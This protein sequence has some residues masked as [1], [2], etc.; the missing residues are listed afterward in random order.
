MD[1]ADRFPFSRPSRR[2]VLGALGAAA[3]AP[4]LA[5]A[6]ALAQPAGSAALAF[7]T[8]P[9]SGERLPAVGM[10]TYL[11]FDVLPG[12]PRDHLREVLR[13]FY[14]GGGRVVDTSPLYGM[15]E[16]S[17][18][19]FATALGITDDLF[20]TNKVWSTGEYLGDDSH[21]RRSLEQSRQRL[22]RERIDVMQ[23]HSLVNV[24]IM[25]PLLNAWKQE[26]RIRFV[27]VTHHEL[28]YFPA[29]AQWVERGEIDTVQVHYSIH[30]RQAEDRILKAA[31]DRGIAVLV[32]MPFEKARLFRI[33]EGRPLPDFAREIG[34]ETWAQFFL[35]WVISHPAVTC[36]LPATT[37]P[38]HASDNIAALRGPL[39]DAE[40]R[41]RMVRHME[42]IPG[43][44]DLAQ[45]PSYPG[46]QFD[47]AV[48]PPRRPAQPPR[49]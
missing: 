34:A 36:V 29:L 40:M 32:N 7:K 44:A 46:K 19:D 9:R 39:P 48:R 1:S 20:I 37:N 45:M 13:R 28:P 6:A 35:K 16:I 24:D 22:W 2:T 12:R 21:A 41:A 14:E 30:T 10:G 49:T 8:L 26:G 18:G 31:A 25:V 11:T 15:S 3:A 5:P 27:G 4:A 33:V 43:F 47:G 42:T 23:V 38:D 17:V